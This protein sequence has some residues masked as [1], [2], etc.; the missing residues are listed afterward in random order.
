M[1]HKYNKKKIIMILKSAFKKKQDLNTAHEV[2]LK[3]STS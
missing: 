1:P 2:G 3:S